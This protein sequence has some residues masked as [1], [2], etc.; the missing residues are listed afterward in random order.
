MIESEAQEKWNS[1]LSRKKPIPSI[2]T[3]SSSQ[4]ENEGRI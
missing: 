2:M 1:E 3:N 4:K